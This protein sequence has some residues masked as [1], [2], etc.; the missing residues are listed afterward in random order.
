MCAARISD[1]E[2]GL[3]IHLQDGN[4]G[5]LCGSH[6]RSGVVDHDVATGWPDCDLCIKKTEETSKPSWLA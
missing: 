5:T 1:E 3:R 6:E 4:G 2:K